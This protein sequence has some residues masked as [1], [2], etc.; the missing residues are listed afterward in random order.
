MPLT[1]AEPGTGTNIQKLN[2]C[3]SYTEQVR[4]VVGK[5]VRWPVGVINILNKLCEHFFVRLARTISKNRMHKDRVTYSIEELH[6]KLTLAAPSQSCLLSL[7]TEPFSL[8]LF[9]GLKLIQPCTMHLMREPCI[10]GC[11][12]KLVRSALDVSHP[13]DST[14]TTHLSGSRYLRMCRCSG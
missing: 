5:W 6:H 14:I 12:G 13:A 11:Y 10:N 2:L 3:E 4:K 7:I 9:T 1:D 8:R